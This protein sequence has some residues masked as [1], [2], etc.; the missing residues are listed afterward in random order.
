MFGKDD[1]GRDT[2]THIYTLKIKKLTGQRV[3]RF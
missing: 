1:L 3:N 2:H